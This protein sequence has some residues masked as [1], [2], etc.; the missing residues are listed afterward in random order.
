MS[1]SSIPSSSQQGRVM[2]MRTSSMQSIHDDGAPVILAPTI[3][4]DLGVMVRGTA[5]ASVTWGLAGSN[6]SERAS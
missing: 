5:M 3:T 6:A 2:R 4:A 1:Q